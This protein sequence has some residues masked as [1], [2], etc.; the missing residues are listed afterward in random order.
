[1][2]CNAVIL[3][4]LNAFRSPSAVII[5]T[6]TGSNLF[7]VAQLQASNSVNENS[8][9]ARFD[10]RINGTNTAYFR[11]FRDQGNNNQPEGVT[12]RRVVIRDVPKMQ[13]SRCNQV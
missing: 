9:A 2:T 3:P 6:G 7:D 13:F 1:M 12:G 10:Y 8:F 5:Q 4:L 11:F